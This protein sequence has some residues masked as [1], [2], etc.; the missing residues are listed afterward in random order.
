MSPFFFLWTLN[1][2]RKYYTH[3][4]QQAHTD[5]LY[6]VRSHI[7]INGSRPLLETGE[8]HPYT[9]LEQY[10]NA[11]AGDPVMYGICTSKCIL[12]PSHYPTAF[13]ARNNHQPFLQR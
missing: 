6:L 5:L 8:T 4:Q 10:A 12:D 11:H 7:A 13:E 1:A 9:Y 3:E 2:L